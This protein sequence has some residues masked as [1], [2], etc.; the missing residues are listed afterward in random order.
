MLNRATEGAFI[1]RM[2]EVHHETVHFSGRVQGVGFRY[3]TL[4]LARGY[5][6]S[7]YVRNLSDGRVLVEAEGTPAEVGAFIAAI[8]EEMNGYIGKTERSA[9]LREPQFKGF[10]IR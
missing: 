7:G 10:M 5:D 9:D 4:H 6:V 8:Q 3:Q 2:A 1:R